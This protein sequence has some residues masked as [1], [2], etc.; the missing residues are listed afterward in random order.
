MIWLLAAAIIFFLKL[1]FLITLLLIVAAAWSLDCR[2]VVVPKLV[3]VS[4]FSCHFVFFPS[5]SQC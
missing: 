1:L 2:T 4:D 3:F 5:F